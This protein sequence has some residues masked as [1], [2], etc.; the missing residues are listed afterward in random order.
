MRV[1]V[2]SSETREQLDA[3]S[4]RRPRHG[5]ERLANRGDEFFSQSGR[6]R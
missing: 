1:A 6:Q 4:L 2:A 3:E 5:A